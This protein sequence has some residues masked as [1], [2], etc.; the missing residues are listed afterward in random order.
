MR[1]STELSHLR[2]FIALGKLCL[3]V[4]VLCMCNTHVHSI[5]MYM[6]V[7]TCV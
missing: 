5:Y 2:Q 1:I 3:Q 7:Y 6:Y 4:S